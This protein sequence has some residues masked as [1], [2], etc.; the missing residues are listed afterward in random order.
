MYTYPE[1]AKTKDGN[2]FWTMPKRPPK[3]II[4]DP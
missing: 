1:D 2:L 4:F 3:P